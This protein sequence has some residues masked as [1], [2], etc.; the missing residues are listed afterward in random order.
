MTSGSGYL[1]WIH[2]PSELEPGHI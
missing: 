2:V 1:T